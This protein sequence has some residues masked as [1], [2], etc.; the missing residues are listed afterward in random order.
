[1]RLGFGLPTF[2]PAA[3]EVNGIARFAADAEKIGATSLWVGDRL[4]TPVDPAVGYSPGSTDI[5]EEFRVAADPLTALAVAAAVTGEVRLG[6]SGINAPWYP[7]AL[8]ARALA[9]IDVA[10][11]G[12]LVA[13]FGSGWS[14]EEYEAA[15]VPF[16]GRGARLDELLDVLVAWWTTNP[17]RHQGPLFT[18]PA[19]H[20]ELKPVQRPRPPIYLGAFGPRALRR[21]GERADGWMPV[22]WAPE[23]FPVA[24]LTQGWETIQEAAGK[25]GRD[26]AAISMI[27]RVNAAAGTPVEVVAEEVLKVR[28]VLPVEDVFVDFT[29]VA[30][31]V[32]HTLDLAGN[33]LDL[34][35]AE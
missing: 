3:N 20:V 32:G 35:S 18:I 4:L 15:G 29:F 13:G 2:G 5:P 34:V 24:Q 1:M 17:V 21:V 8:L 25:A 12:R 9:S 23:A 30:S 10:S 27:L 31:S 16:E 14:P 33:L 7:P 6:S 22:W 11:G 28:S 19:G 26:P